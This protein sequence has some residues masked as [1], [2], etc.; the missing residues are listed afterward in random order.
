MLEFL[1]TIGASELGKAI[2]EQALK[3][4]QSAAEDYVKD[5]FKDCLKEGITSTKPEVTKKAVAQALKEFLVLVQK[6]LEDWEISEAEIRDLYDRPLVQ[7]VKNDL[8]KPILG[9]AFERDCTAIDTIAL[10]EIWKNSN[11]R[12]KPFPE[13]P[14]EFNWQVI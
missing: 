3:L 2:F 5:F 11:F 12:D 1:L 4:G 9:R 7:F 10:T 13:M 14:P 6:E 8:V